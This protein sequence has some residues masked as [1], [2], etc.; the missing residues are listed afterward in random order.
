[1][2]RRANAQ[3]KKQSKS[4]HKTGALINHHRWFSCLAALRN[5]SLFLTIFDSMEANA[6]QSKLSERNGCLSPLMNKPLTNHR[7]GPGLIDNQVRENKRIE[8]KLT[9][10]LRISFTA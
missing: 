4:G 1:M 5:E 8:F 6:S 2:N 9:D 3:A 7:T 10:K